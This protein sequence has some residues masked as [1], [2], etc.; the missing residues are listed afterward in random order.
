MRIVRILALSC[1]PLAGSCSAANSGCGPEWPFYAKTVLKDR[2]F[3]A[4]GTSPFGVATFQPS[5][6]DFMMTGAGSDK[7]AL[8]ALE[9]ALAKD[10][11]ALRASVITGRFDGEIIREKDV[12]SPVVVITHVRDLRILDGK[13]RQDVL[14]SE[15]W[16]PRRA[17]DHDPNQPI[18]QY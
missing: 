15:S 12:D 13:A 7:A 18:V 5:E 17:I 6:C 11:L 4:I 10:R 8:S 16:P 1:L 2:P 14:D 9:Q 3:N